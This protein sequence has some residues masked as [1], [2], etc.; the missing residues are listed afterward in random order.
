[1]LL[2][3][4]YK[5]P[6]L[7]SQTNASLQSSIRSRHSRRTRDTSP[8]DRR[9]TRAHA[10]RRARGNAS[11]R[12]AIGA[13]IS[14]CERRHCRAGLILLGQE[15]RFDKHRDDRASAEREC[16]V[17]E[18][19]QKAADFAAMRGDGDPGV[20]VVA[21]YVVKN[22]L[23]AGILCTGRLGDYASP[24]LVILG[25]V[26]LDLEGREEVLDVSLVAAVVAGV[27]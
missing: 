12:W 10:S 26:W 17:A 5:P 13:E 6:P 22:R 21:E 20:V 11:D 25:E 19:S 24:K 8:I 23:G 4:H 18:N 9:T 2:S 16:S 7:K 27:G 14:G 3:S 15:L 1:M